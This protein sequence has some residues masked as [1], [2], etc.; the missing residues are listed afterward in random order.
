MEIIVQPPPT[1]EEQDLAAL[2][3][4]LQIFSSFLGPLVI[5]FLKP[6]SRFVAFHALQVIFWQ[7]LLWVVALL[8]AQLVVAFV[9]M[10]LSSQAG[11]ADQPSPVFLAV[12]ILLMFAMGGTL[13]SAVLAIVYAIKA[14]KGQW[15]QY[16]LVGAWAKRAVGV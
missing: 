9:S 15:A 11:A 14:M 1:R 5:Y 7:L 12:P 2:A 6:S 13:M 8:S 4:A 10:S 16:P 3:H